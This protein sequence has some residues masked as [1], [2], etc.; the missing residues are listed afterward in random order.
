[1]S[2]RVG[3]M[4]ASAKTAVVLMLV[5]AGG[6]AL[7]TFIEKGM[8]TAAA[9]A[10]VYYSPLFMLLQ[11]LMVFNY[12]CVAQRL[13]LWE[14]RK[15]GA[16]LVH[17]AFMVILAGA[18]VSHVFS[19]EGI[20][21]LR[22][23]EARDYLEVQ[24]DRGLV[25]HTL[26]FTVE[27]Q[28]FI[29][30][31][32]P[33]SES[34]SS[35]ESRVIVRL[36]GEE[37]LERIYMNNVL[38]LEG[39]RFFQAS[40]DRDEQGTILSVSRDVAGRTITYV[41]YALLFLGLLCS[42]FG[43][44]SRFMQLSRMLKSG[45]VGLA[46][47][48]LFPQSLLAE[49]SAVEL[50]QHIL[51]ATGNL[52]NELGKLGVREL[53]SRF[54]GIGPAKAVTIMAAIE[55]GKR[56]AA[57]EPMQRTQIRS[58]QDIY[59]LMY[60]LLAD[61]PHEEFWVIYLSRS[62]RILDKLRIGQGGTG[63]VITDIRLILKPGIQLLASGIIAVHNHPSGNLQPSRQDNSLTERLKQAAALLDIHLMDHL[64]ITDGKY[65]SYADEG[66]L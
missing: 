44:E 37:R 7:A 36:D 14:R 10:L 33:G 35:Y 55:L 60:P 52:L 3:R 49:E 66:Q 13:R 53:T 12:I 29:L 50:A 2:E 46:L 20:L 57:E 5:Y 6:L 21:H 11:L 38:D 31:R 58:S 15:W 61:L 17:G 32:Y 16:L 23:G 27:L 26:P 25:R 42:L 45:A 56:R 18:F 24:T 19:E 39:Y 47:L 54:K 30:T 65:Y 63:E 40:Y 59:R 62:Q 34:P 1:M 41:G 8:G 48:A 28:D 22:E 43:K 9:K 51:N 64:I 4:M